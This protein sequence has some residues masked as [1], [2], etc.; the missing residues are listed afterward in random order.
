M[1]DRNCERCGKKHLSEFVWL[2]LNTVTG[3][4]E[5]PGSVPPSESQGLFP[6]GAACA[7]RTLSS[8]RGVSTRNMEP[9]V[10]PSKI[11]PRLH[12]SNPGNTGR[13]RRKS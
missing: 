11:T 2:E 4:Y 7:R 8:P 10:I 5:T 12:G 1:N 6:F 3:R 9:L 13:K